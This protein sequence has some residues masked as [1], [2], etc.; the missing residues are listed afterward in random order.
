[1]DGGLRKEDQTAE[2]GGKEVM[3]TM[4][5]KIQAEEVNN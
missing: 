4:G 2:G 1:M 3:L 5:H